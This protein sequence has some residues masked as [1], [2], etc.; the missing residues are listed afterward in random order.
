MSYLLN[1][2]NER[3]D[4]ALTSG[5]IILAF[6]C[7][8]L[9][10]RRLSGVVSYACALAQRFVPR[11][12]ERRTAKFSTLFEFQKGRSI[13]NHQLRSKLWH[14]RASA[15]SLRRTSLPHVAGARQV[16]DKRHS[17]V[18]QLSG[19]RAL[20]CPPPPLKRSNKRLLCCSA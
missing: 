12:P 19:C 18:L 4:A 11:S 9:F 3:A 17:P 14:E 2:A 10:V 1:I 6:I 8:A 15:Q 5:T 20:K 16:G 13:S 7:A